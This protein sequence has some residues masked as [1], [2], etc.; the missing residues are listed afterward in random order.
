MIYS[1]DIFDTLITRTFK[2]PYGIFNYIEK[3]C[4]CG[5]DNFTVN[6]IEAEKNARKKTQREEITLDEIYKELQYK[7]C[8][9]N[10]TIEKLK[11][12]EFDTELN[13]TI[14]IYENIHYLRELI[15][16]KN[17]V[18]LISDMY[19]QKKQ[20]IQLLLKNKIPIDDI[21][22]F[23]SSEY[24][25][26]KKSG[27]LYK[28]VKKKLGVKANE[29]QH[30]GDNK[31]SDYIVPKLLGY[32]VKLYCSSHMNK[33]EKI[34]DAVNPLLSEQIRL[35]RIT[36]SRNH[37]KEVWETATDIV[38]P[39]T[40]GYISWIKQFID[41]NGLNKVFFVSRDG[42]LMYSVWK[43]LFGNSES[44]YSD[45]IYGSRKV[46]YLP[47]I[48]NEKKYIYAVSNDGWITTTNISKEEFLEQFN[49]EKN[50][51]LQLQNI[52]PMISQMSNQDIIKDRLF[53]DFVLKKA[54]KEREI[55][56]KYFK[57]IGIADGDTLALVDLGWTGKSLEAARTIIREIGP[58][59]K[60]YGIVLGKRNAGKDK[61]WLKAWL[62]PEDKKCLRSEVYMLETIYAATHETVIR[63]KEKNGLVEPIFNK[64]GRIKN[65]V[66]DLI[67][68][69][70]SATCRLAYQVKRNHIRINTDAI[71]YYQIF[72]EF[73][74]NPQ[75]NNINAYCNYPFS[76]YS[77]DKKYKILAKK[78]KLFDV[79]KQLQFVNLLA[80]KTKKREYEQNVYWLEASAKISGIIDYILVKTDN[81]MVAFL[82]KVDKIIGK[83]ND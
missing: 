3:S 25:A 80:K 71:N 61:D 34:I 56:K 18:L 7:L 70:Q 52:N 24:M 81:K 17:K 82:Y 10:K 59:I 60:V 9:D 78:I 79:I 66:L 72:Q 31:F 23:I 45:Y 36:Y 39:I 26:T 43:I 46:W 40:L 19:L 13:F 83:K 63:Y 47:S 50:E 49:F 44:I 74:F 51:L 35:N 12:Y 58:N 77:G 8:L 65:D 68:C 33:Y 41:K 27:K 11:Q 2:S 14:P 38:A 75:N 57:Q 22:I 69:Q 21:D 15:K 76:Q 48:T 64:D 53:I 55:V 4:N 1:F 32:H 28:I 20:I 6:R 37:L 42:Q 16:H 29:I 73:V 54:A 30:M 5:V 67:K 62:I